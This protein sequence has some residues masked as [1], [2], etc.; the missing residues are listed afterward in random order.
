MERETMEIK[1]KPIG[2]VRVKEH[3][4]TKPLRSSAR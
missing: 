4:F 3:I 1:L 2:V